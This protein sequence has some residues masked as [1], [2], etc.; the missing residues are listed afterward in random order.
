MA[1]P[2]RCGWK[3]ADDE[4]PF[5]TSISRSVGSPGCWTLFQDLERRAGSRKSEP[6]AGRAEAEF[7]HANAAAAAAAF[8]ATATP[9]PE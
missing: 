6:D 2:R 1:R 3:A 8:G 5:L 7:S 9:V 4:G